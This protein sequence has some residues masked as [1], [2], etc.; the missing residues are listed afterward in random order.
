MRLFLV[1]A[2]AFQVLA[3]T[4]S[5]SSKAGAAPTGNAQNGKRIFDSYGCYQCHGHDAHGGAG[6][7]LAPN[8]IAFE[9]FSRYVRKPTGE[10]PPYTSKVVSDQ[11]LADIYAF[12]GTIPAPPPVKDIPILN[13]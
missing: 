1:A 7:R 2:I 9:R 13:H 4:P 11:E 6:A 12:L 5:T 3:Q 8:P 10:M